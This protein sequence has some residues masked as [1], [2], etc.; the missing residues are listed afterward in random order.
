MMITGSLYII[1]F[2]YIGE[3][4]LITK[5]WIGTN[6]WASLFIIPIVALIISVSIS[7]PPIEIIGKASYHIFLVQMI[8]YNHKSFFY[9]YLSKRYEKLLFNVI[10]CTCLGILFYLVE[11]PI[12]KTIRNRS[13]KLYTY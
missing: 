8:Y 10:I 6:M 9:K 13:N 1:L 5:W 11:S 7:C 2:L 4:P 12:S 3:K